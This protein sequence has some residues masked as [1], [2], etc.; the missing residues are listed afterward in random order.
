MSIGNLC[1]FVEKWENYQYILLQKSILY[2]A[3]EGEG[4]NNLG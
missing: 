1:L 3:K 4:G 2:G